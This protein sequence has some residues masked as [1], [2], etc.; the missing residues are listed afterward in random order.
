MPKG[1]SKMLVNASVGGYYVT[2]DIA[3]NFDPRLS[4][5]NDKGGKG[6]RAWDRSC[7]SNSEGRLFR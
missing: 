3:N 7:I 6:E 4:L 5:L 1:K 2:I